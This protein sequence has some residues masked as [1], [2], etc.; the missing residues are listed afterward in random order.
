MVKENIFP[1]MFVLVLLIVNPLVLALSNFSIEL[2]P[3]YYSNSREI[4]VYNNET[5]YD[6]VSFDILG[7]NMDKTSRIVNLTIA[8]ISPELLEGKF[9]DKEEKLISGQEKVLWSS[10]IIDLTKV[11]E[12]D[13]LFIVGV[14]GKNEVLKQEFYAEDQYLLSLNNPN[15]TNS[16]TD[17]IKVIGEKV[18]EGNWQLGIV[19]VICS[20]IIIAFV[21]WKNKVG[22]KM[23]LWRNKNA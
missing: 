22:K 18:W 5:V 17:I 8:K 13:L 6:G 2:D 12:K 20:I 11:E 10:K 14:K 3:H 1:V 16:E 15:M 21:G 7:T 23:E 4:L 19:T 9:S